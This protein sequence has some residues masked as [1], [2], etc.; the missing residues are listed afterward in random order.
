MSKKKSIKKTEFPC[1]QCWS[2]TKQMK[3]FDNLRVCEN[4]ECPNFSLVQVAERALNRE[5]KKDM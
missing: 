5:N 1:V 3:D 4:V 2:E